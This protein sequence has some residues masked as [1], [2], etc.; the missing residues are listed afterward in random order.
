MWHCDIKLQ[1]DEWSAEVVRR[2]DA[3]ARARKWAWDEWVR[4]AFDD[5]GASRVYRF[6]EGPVPA[7][8][9]LKCEPGGTLPAAS[10]QGLIELKAKPW[11]ELWLPDGGEFLPFL[12]VP[13]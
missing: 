8:P 7:A 5:D 2:E 12:E 10:L 6:I 4:R 9:L 3:T 11:K 13:V 1:I